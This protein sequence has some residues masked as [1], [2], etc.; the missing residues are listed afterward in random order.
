MLRWPRELQD[1][2]V[3]VRSG[4][5]QAIKMTP[6]FFSE[7]LER[8]FHVVDFLIQRIELLVVTVDVSD[9]PSDF[10]GGMFDVDIAAIYANQ[11]MGTS[12]TQTR[13]G[14]RRVRD[15]SLTVDL[16]APTKEH[17]I[18]CAKCATTHA[19][20]QALRRYVN[21]SVGDPVID[22]RGKPLLAQLAFLDRWLDFWLTGRGSHCG[23][24]IALPRRWPRVQKL[25]HTHTHTRT[26]T[27]Y[28]YS[29]SPRNH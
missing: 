13:L 24:G 26:H 6:S 11:P 1:R 23:L 8:V 27:L 17:R 10:E 3:Q 2:I 12:I 4:L 20:E 28:I 22:L 29:V 9:Q 21:V 18:W 7:Y 15:N 19:T 16:P 5:L 14:H 25:E